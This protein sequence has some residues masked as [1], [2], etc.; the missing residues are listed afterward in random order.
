M[1]HAQPSHI[2]YPWNVRVIRRNNRKVYVGCVF[3]SSEDAA[4]RAAEKFR[5]DPD[6][7]ELHGF[8]GINAKAIIGAEPFVVQHAG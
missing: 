5:V 6:D 7:A 4:K 3:E 8:T 1:P 2:L